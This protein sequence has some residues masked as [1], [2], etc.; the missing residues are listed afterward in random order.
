MRDKLEEHINLADNQYG[1]RTGKST[2]E[3]VQQVIK[4]TGHVWLAMVCIDIKNAF[5]TAKWTLIIQKLKDCGTP[6]C[7]VN[8]ISS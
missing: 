8:L 4:R 3:A 1:F 6:D 5:K 2:I 7:L